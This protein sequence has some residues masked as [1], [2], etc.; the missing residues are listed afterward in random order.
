MDSEKGLRK[1]VTIRRFANLLDASL[2]KGL[3]QSSGIECFLPD[4][5]MVRVHWGVSNSISG[6]RLQVK[7]EDAEESLAILNQSI[8]IASEDE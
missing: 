6:V 8:P 7:I 1:L 2:A 5:N 4:E 3:L